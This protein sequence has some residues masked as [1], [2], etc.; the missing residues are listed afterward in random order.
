MD[1]ELHGRVALVV[2]GTGLIGAAVVERLRAEGATAIAA[3]R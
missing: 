2:G 3:A 1:L